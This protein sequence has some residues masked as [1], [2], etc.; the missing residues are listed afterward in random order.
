MSKAKK[1]SKKEKG[2]E[3]DDAFGDEEGVEY[4]ESKPRKEKKM[5]NDE[6]EELE[7]ELDEEI[8]K[9][10]RSSGELSVDQ[11]EYEMKTSKPIS[12]LKKGDRMNIDGKEYIIDTHYCMIDHGN[13]KEMAIEIYD[14]NDKDFQLRYFNDQVDSTIEFYELQEILYIKKV[15]K[16]IEW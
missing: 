10:E 3:L 5:S 16:K 13:T 2:V 7:N 12:Q 14:A 8:D 4:A 6:D 11:P 9:I 1:K 15:F